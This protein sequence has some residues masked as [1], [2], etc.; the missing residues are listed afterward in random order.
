VV[1]GETG[2]RLRLAVNVKAATADAARQIQQVAQGLL[3]LASLNAA[4]N[5]DFK[6]LTEAA[7][8]TAAGQVVTLGAEVPVSSVIQRMPQ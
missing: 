5:A 8:I 6:V 4:Q 3:A 2:D 7:S 1:L